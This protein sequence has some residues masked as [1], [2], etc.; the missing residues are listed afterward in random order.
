MGRVTDGLL[1]LELQGQ[2]I[3]RMVGWGR[4]GGF[5]LPNVQACKLLPP[6]T[7]CNVSRP[8]GRLSGGDESLDANQSVAEIVSVGS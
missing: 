7:V 4:G 5:T 2:P 6:G 3:S 8:A 1:D